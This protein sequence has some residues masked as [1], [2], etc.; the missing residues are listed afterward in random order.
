MEWEKDT[1]ARTRGHAI[2]R[3][4]NKS[5]DDVADRCPKPFGNLAAFRSTWG[6]DS[7]HMAN[8]T[9][10]LLFANRIR[11]ATGSVGW[12]QARTRGLVPIPLDGAGRQ[13]IYVLC[14][15]KSQG[16]V[17]N[18]SYSSRIVR[19]AYRA[20][21]IYRYNGRILRWYLLTVYPGTTEAL[22]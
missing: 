10:P 13:Q 15:A 9:R 20:R 4:Y 6:N 7:Y 3:H 12:W 8:N 16:D 22:G 11:I 14:T 5:I 21:A 2:E 19:G 18:P 1:K 17:Y